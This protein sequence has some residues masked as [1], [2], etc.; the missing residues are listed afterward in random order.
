[1]LFYFIYWLI[2]PILWLMLFLTTIINPKVR[3]HWRNEKKT[4]NVVKQK[5]KNNNKVI[6]H[7]HSASMG[8][9]EQL[10]PVINEINRNKYFI[11]LSF[12]SPTGFKKQKHITIVDAICYH[13]FDFIWSA[14]FFFKKLN[15]QHY[16]TTRNDIWPNHLFVA[17]KL[18]IP[19][20]LINANFY[21]KSHKNSFLIKII[22]KQ[23]FKNIDMV[24]TGSKRLKI[25]LQLLCSN[26]KIHI[27][28]DSRIDQVIK[29][30]NDNQSDLLPNIYKE[31]KTII[32]GS[33]EYSDN[34]YLFD[35]LKKLYPNG[36]IDLENKNHCLIIVPHEIFPKNIN[37]IYQ[38]LKKINL[39]PIYY[40]NKNNLNESR[41][42]IINNVGLLADLYK[43]SDLAYVGA[44]FDGG[45]HSV[46]EPMI[47]ANAIGFGPNYEIV[48]MAVSLV[49]LKL[50]KII[51]SQND[52]TSFLD[53][54]NNK[55]I[56]TKIKKQMEIFA[57]E[58]MLSSKN[59]INKILH[60]E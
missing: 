48:D 36:D 54:I 56:L 20:A 42:V 17:K 28:G 5:I 22:Y 2:S 16:I 23:V 25:N 50:A 30:K 46:I 49:N 47:Y 1:M 18:N 33:I 44:G 35:S 19:T 43:Y 40:D 59:I 8:E 58:Q 57:K 53:L 27:T 9:F 45:V 24:L 31:S 29:R 55:K 4:L 11:L 41:V 6:I 13:P 60:D 3:H 39:N 51:K 38:E 12:F 10:K 15:I 7:L 32:F 52:F 14:F 34:K 37:K 26:K 21:K